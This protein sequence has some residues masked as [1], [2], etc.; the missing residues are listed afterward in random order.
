MGMGGGGSTGP[1]RR[2]GEGNIQRR[3]SP[4]CCCCSQRCFRYCGHS[5]ARGRESMER[6]DGLVP[7]TR[8]LE[9]FVESRRP[10][11]ADGRKPTCSTSTKLN[12]RPGAVR[13]ELSGP[14]NLQVLR[15][16]RVSNRRAAYEGTKRLRS[17][18]HAHQ[19]AEVEHQTHGQGRREPQHLDVCRGAAT[20]RPPSQHDHGTT[21]RD[22]VRVSESHPE[23]HAQFDIRSRDAERQRVRVAAA[24]AA[25]DPDRRPAGSSDHLRVRLF[26]E[27][28][29][30]VATGIHKRLEALALEKTLGC[31]FSRPINMALGRGSCDEADVDI[32]GI[33][34]L[35][36]RI[37]SAIEEH[38]W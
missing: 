11:P 10:R 17:H 8:R 21:R 9:P 22:V 2:H 15:D 33:K 35:C 6:S 4:T 7:E 28:C 13:R 20:T 3:R 1:L 36:S 16:T 5:A 30:H 26:A 37:S 19:H 38:T 18:A 24:T 34:V 27:T 12:G 25:G 32:R 29:M 23:A 31:G 14:S